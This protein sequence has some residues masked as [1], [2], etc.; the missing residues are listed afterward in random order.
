MN[1]NKHSNNK[2]KIIALSGMIMFCLSSFDMYPLKILQFF[3][4][5]RMRKSSLIYC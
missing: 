3:Y 5:S 1:I 2:L 4:R